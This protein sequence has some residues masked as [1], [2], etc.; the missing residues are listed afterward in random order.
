MHQIRNRK[1]QNGRRRGAAVV[2][3]ALVA[4][5][6]LTLTVGCIELGRA[7][8]VQQLLTNASREGAR[9]AGYDTTTST[10]TVAAEVN[11][12]LANVN[13]SGATTVVAPSN[14]SNMSDGQQVSVTVS[15]PF[16]N[17][18]WLP[19]PFFL[20]NQTLQ[21]TSVMCRQPAP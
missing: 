21:A 5:V 4:P 7:I 15:V 20:A 8:V 2:E 6:F 3:F 18:S 10:S 11:S 19:K 9:V 16:N 1:Q 17:V 12:Y 13:I 14:L